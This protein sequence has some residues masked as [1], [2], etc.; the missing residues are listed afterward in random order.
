M[1]HGVHGQQ[2]PDPRLLRP[3]PES[4][5]WYSLNYSQRPGWMLLVRTH[6][7]EIYINQKK[8]KQNKS[9]PI[10]ELSRTLQGLHVYIYSKYANPAGV[11]SGAG[12]LA[13]GVAETDSGAATVSVAAAG[14]GAI[15]TGLHEKIAIRLEYT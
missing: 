9:K 3:C 7:P 6:H 2:C 4:A 10:S 12:V 11:D 1:Q 5:E 15:A 13:G 14:V 8:M